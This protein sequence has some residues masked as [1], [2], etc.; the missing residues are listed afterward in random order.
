MNLLRQTHNLQ[1]NEQL[2]YFTSSS[3]WADNRHLV[4]LSDRNGHPNIY[5]R[6]M[7]TGEE[8]AL[9]ENHEGFLKSYVYFDG[10]PYQ[11]LG[12]ASVSLDPVSGAV[13]YLQGR[14]V[15]RVDGSGKIRVLA[16]LPYEQMTAFT[17]VSADGKRL[18]VPTTDARALD[19][20]NRLPGRP[21]YN[22][23]ARVQEESLCSYLWVFDT[24]TGTVLL[25]EPVARSW[26]THVQFSPVD[27]DLIL[28]N[29]EWPGDCG[30]RRMWLFD[31]RG[32]GEA[33]HL[34][35]RM[36]G[37]G[38]SR[39]DWTCH[40]MWERDG[41]A[42]IYHGQYA[43]GRSYLGRVRPDGSDVREVLVPEG[44]NAYGHFTVGEPG[45]L[46]TD[47]CFQEPE[48]AAERNGQWISRVEVDWE[49]GTSRWIP[50]CRHGSSWDSQ[51]SHPHPIFDHAGER[52]YFTSDRE[53]KR[54]IYST[55]GRPIILDGKGEQHGFYL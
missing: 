53:G 40:E 33:R 41:Q 50:L 52:I 3:L 8:M 45:V 29:H 51:D 42:I 34:R 2:L 15:C 31:A 48:D 11:G 27:P 49:N 26:I 43:N 37:Q 20:D 9:S 32:I 10:N 30:I 36:E 18:C 44:W 6:N 13:Y 7:A 47:G 54:A 22:I 46:V 12:K 25:R 24:E 5:L 1:A 39:A 19:G 14:Q 21:E 16:E 35:L 4:F 28:Y 55:V 23:D 17:H 38:R